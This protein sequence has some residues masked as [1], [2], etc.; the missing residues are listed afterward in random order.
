MRDRERSLEKD[1]GEFRIALVGDSVVE[2]V[3]LKPDEVMNIRMEKLLAKKG[4]ANT[5]VLNFSVEGIGTDQEF[6]LYRERVRAS[7]PTWLC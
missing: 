5:E 3:H 2:G 6:I 1:P 4:Y 7:I